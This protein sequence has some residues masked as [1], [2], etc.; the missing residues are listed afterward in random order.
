M[1]K[2]KGLKYKKL[3]AIVTL[4]IIAVYIS[5]IMYVLIK[6]PTDTFTVEQGTVSLEETT[7]GYIIRDE[8]VV[9]GENY[10]KWNG[11]DC[12][13]RRKSGKG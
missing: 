8:V 5:Y 6:E 7:V 10:K 2:V 13:R 9:Q 3:L 11:A 4:T 12:T 1:K